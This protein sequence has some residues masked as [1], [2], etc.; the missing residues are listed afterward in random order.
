MVAKAQSQLGELRGKIIDSKTKKPVDYASIQLK[1]NGIIKAQV[2]SDDDGDF[3][4]KPLQPGDY[5]LEVSSIGYQ[6][7]SIS[8]ISVI[9]DQATYQN[10]SLVP[11]GGKELETVVIKSKKVLVDREGK[12]GG[13]KTAEEIMR[14]PQRNANMVANTFAGVDARAGA[15]PTIRGARADGTAYY[16]D[17]VRV[18]SGSVTIPQ[19]AIDQIQVI[20]SGTPALYGDFTGVPSP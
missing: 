11:S 18:A 12:G 13:T 15:T 14:L 10:V 16:I 6:G 5:T 7:Q 9:S 17:G 20:T 19:N 2:K 8:G 3:F 1:L 4:I